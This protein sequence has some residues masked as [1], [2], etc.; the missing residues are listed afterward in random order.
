M[1]PGASWGIADAMRTQPTTND[2]P[3]G[4][5]P[6]PPWGDPRPALLLALCYGILVWQVPATGLI[7]ISVGVLGALA[8]PAVRSRR[9][10]GMARG[11]LRFCAFWGVLKFALDM[12]LPGADPAVASYGAV[13]LAGRLALLGGIGMALTLVASARSL[14]LALAWLLRP[15]MGEAAW[16]P[17]LA[18]AL[19]LHFL[20]MTQQAMAQVGRCA[21]LRRP[22]GGL[23]RRAVLIPAA[24]LRILGQ[25]TWQQ[26]V[27]VAVRGLDGPEAWT[28]RFAP[29]PWAWLQALLLAGAG[30]A[31][32]L[33]PA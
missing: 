25:R 29:A 8:H 10:P 33:L 1:R 19:M 28:P 27:A 13:L 9:R 17:A 4:P 18:L 15:V 2:A 16:R 7:V 21:T 22:H 11:M 6:R 24:V 20:P 3:S 32:F 23:R 12:T 5:R 14:A 30:C 31:L 26:T